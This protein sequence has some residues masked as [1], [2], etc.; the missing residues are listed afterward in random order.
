MS[1]T[2][3]RKIA[4]TAKFGQLSRPFSVAIGRRIVYRVEPLNPALKKYRGR[5]CTV[6][7]CNFETR[8]ILVLFKGSNV[9]AWIDPGMLV[10]DARSM[11]A[12]EAV[13]YKRVI[14]SMRRARVPA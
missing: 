9:Q 13:E 7:D 5:R 4:G 14:V 8:L 6:V 3:L 2:P 1:G 10:E 11:A 12:V